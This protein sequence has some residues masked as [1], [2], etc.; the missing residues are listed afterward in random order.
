M[1]NF[2]IF[3]VDRSVVNVPVNPSRFT[4]YKAVLR[5]IEFENKKLDNTLLLNRKFKKH[6]FSRLKKRRE[7]SRIIPQLFRRLMQYQTTRFTEY[8]EK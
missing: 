3:H 8:G 5:Y 7:N 4:V 1:I 2:I 6:I